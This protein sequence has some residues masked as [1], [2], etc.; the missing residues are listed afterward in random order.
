MLTDQKG[1]SSDDDSLTL[2][3]VCRGIYDYANRPKGDSSDDD[4]E[5]DEAEGGASTNA[6][7]VVSLK[8]DTN[9]DN[10][11]SSDVS[12]VVV[13]VD[14]IFPGYTTFRL[15]G[16]FAPPEDRLLLFEN[17]DAPKNAAALSRAAKRKL[18]LEDKK[19][20]RAADHT[21]KRGFSTGQCIS[22]EGLFV[23]K[24]MQ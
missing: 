19:I 8:N 16:P 2:F 12:D 23:Q 17:N 10:S 9:E 3:F 20:D 15:W 4:D 7:S 24:K 6:E 13:P 14:Y 5:V 11:D 1:G 21:S 18:E 22:I